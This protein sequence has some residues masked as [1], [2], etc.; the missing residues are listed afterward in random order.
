MR[1]HQRRTVFTVEAEE[2]QINRLCEILD[3]NLQGY[4]EE[5]CAVDESEFF[6]G[7]YER[8]TPGRIEV[9][10]G[11]FFVIDNLITLICEW[12]SEM[13]VEEFTFFEWAEWPASVSN[14]TS[15]SIG[16]GAV[17]CYRGESHFMNTYNWALDKCDELAG[18]GQ[19][20]T[21]EVEADANLVE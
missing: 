2:A 15:V 19:N 16:G 17:V 4:K 8:M 10:S 18:V 5:K 13:G 14:P 3:D 11:E 9:R 1:N 6:D 21:E 20:E 12:Q 7:S